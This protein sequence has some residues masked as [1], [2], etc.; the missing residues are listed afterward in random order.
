MH[1]IK[2]LFLNKINQTIQGAKKFP[3]GEGKLPKNTIFQNLGG[4]SPLNYYVSVPARRCNDLQHNE[5]IY[6]K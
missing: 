5:L 2:Y 6:T 4:S 1:D 3:K